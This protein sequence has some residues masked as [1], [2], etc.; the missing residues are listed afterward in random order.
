VERIAHNAITEKVGLAVRGEYF[1]D[2]DGAQMG[3]PQALWEVTLTAGY[4]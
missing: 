1:E 2:K 4:K 3:A